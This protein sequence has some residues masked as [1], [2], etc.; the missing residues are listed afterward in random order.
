MK[1]P[2]V[3]L[4]IILVIAA[5]AVFIDIPR[6]KGLKIGRLER[7]GNLYLGLD[8]QGGM[9][10][11]LE[12]DVEPGVA[13]SAEQMETA[14][15][16]LENRSNGLG[17]SEVVFQIAGDSRIIA[18]FPG[19]TDTD[20][21]LGTLKGTGLLE[22]VDTGDKA[23]NEGDPIKTDIT[24]T[25]DKAADMNAETDET[26][27]EETGSAD[28]MMNETTETEVEEAD[29]NETIY[30]TVLTGSD[31][32]TVGVEMMNAT[33]PV[34]T[35]ELKDEGA[36]IFGDFT[37]NNI[38]RFLTI[39]LDGKVISSPRINSA[40][41]DGAGMI[42][43]NFTIDSA[44]A[45]AVQLKYGALPVPLKIVEYKMIGASLGEDSL[46]KSLI[47][48]LIGLAIACL[49]MLIY[50][51]LPGLVAILTIVFYG[52]VTLAVYKLIPVTLSLAGIAGFLLTTGSAF[53]SNILM[54]ERLKEELR[55]GRS[56]QHAA[57]M[58]WT[59]A[60][61][62]IRDSNIAT[63][64]TAAILFYFGSSFGATVVKGFAVSLM[65]GVVISLLSSY[66]VTRTLLYYF[67]RSVKDEA[68][69]K[70]KVFGL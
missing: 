1:K 35:F 69:V 17:V 24:A 63:L 23:F 49:F 67:T 29:E 12:A 4:V 45:L 9:Q 68:D 55:D 33:T 54:F 2:I 32:K 25:A 56:V 10:V 30:H 37:T 58:C 59:K 7:T 60:W 34:V 40:I 18:E 46:R 27:E 20:E 43:G 50:Y 61:S 14:R 16:I 22:F 42:T 51:R 70:T 5:L 47:A 53:D 44:N 21:V 41:T 48:G 57:S 8:L 26:S 36:K 38:N 3:N 11:L 28:K 13:V 19:V 15:T 6:E 64:I 52:L 31:I 66:L 62:S 39:V 65:I